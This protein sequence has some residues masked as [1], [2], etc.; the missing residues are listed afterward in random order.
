MAQGARRFTPGNNESRGE[1]P[2]FFDPKDF[3]LHHTRA[4]LN[5]PDFG[6]G[7]SPP[8]PPERGEEKEANEPGGGAHPETA[9]AARSGEG[10][11]RVLRLLCIYV[12][13][14]PDSSL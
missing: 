5:R 4:Q 10:G 1:E 11:G 12:T 6:A 7:V 13:S 14:R 8:P 3:Q 2:L 9:A